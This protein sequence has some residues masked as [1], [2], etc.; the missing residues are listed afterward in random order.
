[1]DAQCRTSTVVLTA[2]QRKHLIQALVLVMEQK[3]RAVFAT[4]IQFGFRGLEN[5]AD[6]DLISAAVEAGLGITLADVGLDE[7]GSPL[8]EDWMKALAPG[9]EVF[10][11]DPEEEAVIERI[12]AVNAEGISPDEDLVFRENWDGLP[13]H[14]K[15]E[16]AEQAGETWP[17]S[18]GVYTISEIKTESGKI[19]SFNTIIVIR[20]FEGS[21][22]EVFAHELRNGSRA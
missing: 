19:E 18:T 9:G 14:H 6:A 16:L 8:M 3:P 17:L 2:D 12:L 4:M 20:N 7:S 11:R 15:I 22:A 5:Y 1:M 13:E 10:W 21:E